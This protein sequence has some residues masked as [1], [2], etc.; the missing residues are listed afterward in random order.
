[1][2][3]IAE[4]SERGGFMGVFTAGLLVNPEFLRVLLR[5]FDDC[6]T[7]WTMHRTNYWG[8]TYRQL[9]LEVCPRLTPE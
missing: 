1:M 6:V 7:D 3:D 5:A 9:G 4:P 2:A 8:R